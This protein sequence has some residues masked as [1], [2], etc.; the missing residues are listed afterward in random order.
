M[1]TWTT[2]DGR[3][4]A[5]LTSPDGTLTATV[6]PSL[7]MICSSLTVD[8]AELLGQREGLA[9]YADRGAT[10]GIP[11]LHPWANRLGA[12][13]LAGHGRDTVDPASPLVPTDEHGLPIHGVRLTDQA[14]E[15]DEAG[16]DSEG[17][18]AVAATLDV[19]VCPEILMLFPFP[20]RVG[21][22]MALDDEGLEIRTQVSA[23]GPDP[24]PIAFGW[25]PYVRLPGIERPCWRV[26][27]P[28]A[29]RAVLDGL[30]LPTGLDVPVAIPD[31]PLGDAVYDD[32]FPSVAADTRLAVEGGGRRIEVVFGEGYR[33]AQVY[34]P[35]DS[36]VLA[37]EPMTA[38]TNA[39]VTGEGLQWV[40]PGESFTASFR[41][42]VLRTP[43]AAFSPA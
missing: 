18:A 12:R 34:A 27:L 2:I 22:R 7:A 20:H 40:T 6:V 21:V 36:E 17:R 41:V 13:R 28:L 25:H 15:I 26:S 42:L 11:L 43:V 5:V 37:L 19:G 39:M 24:V 4:A 33:V 31:G 23:T 32:L 8:G 14:W 38:P 30:G 29:R 35:H 1:T 16:V 10:M 9:A 3:E